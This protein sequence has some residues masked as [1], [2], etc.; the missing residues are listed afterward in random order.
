MDICNAQ[1]LVNL[2]SKWLSHW[3]EGKRFYLEINMAI[4]LAS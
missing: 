1:K 2:S 3:K 4:V